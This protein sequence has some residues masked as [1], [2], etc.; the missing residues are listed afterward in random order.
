MDEFYRF[1]LFSFFLGFS[2]FVFP[3]VVYPE[4]VKSM[5]WP[6]FWTG[7]FYF[8]LYMV[9]IDEMVGNHFSPFWF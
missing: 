6:K 8:T 3:Y 9:S 2:A 5:D 7:L 4:M 1:V